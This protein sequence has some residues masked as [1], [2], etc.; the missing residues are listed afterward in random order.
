M[1]AIFE[2]A[3]PRPA[4]AAAAAAAVRTVR[5]GGVRRT[6]ASDEDSDFD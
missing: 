6:S 3:Q 1:G 4:A 5:Q 2:D